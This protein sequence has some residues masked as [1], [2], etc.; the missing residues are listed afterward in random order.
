MDWQGSGGIIVSRCGHDQ[1][2]NVEFPTSWVYIAQF[3]KDFQE[4]VRACLVLFGACCTWQRPAHKKHL[5][6][7]GVVQETNSL[8][9]Q[10]RWVQFVHIPWKSWVFWSSPN[11]W[12]PPMNDPRKNTYLVTGSWDRQVITDRNI[13]PRKLRC[14]CSLSRWFLTDS[15]MGFITILH[16]LGKMCYISIFSNHLKK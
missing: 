13:H 16:H 5:R 4:G 3:A 14:F 2:W 7:A 9:Q 11:R 6:I 15:T 8:P 12:K 10:V 1:I